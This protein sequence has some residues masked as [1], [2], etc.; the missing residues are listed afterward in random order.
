MSVVAIG[1]MSG[2]SLDGVDAALITTDGQNMLACGAW[3][4][5]PYDDAIRARLRKALEQGVCDAS[6][7]RALTLWHANAVQAL[8]EAANMEAD[9]V[10]VIGFHGQTIWHDPT[11]GTSVQAGDGALLAKETGID[12][13]YQFRQA[14]LAHGGQG[15]PLAPLFHRAVLRSK[16][17]AYPAVFLNIGGVANLTWVG[18]QEAKEDAILAFDTGPGNALMDDWMA[19]HTGAPYD[20]DGKLAAR[21]TVDADLVTQWMADPFFAQTPPK[22]LDRNAFATPGLEGFNLEDGLACLQAFTVEAIVRACDHL[23]V[24]PRVWYATGGGVHN[25]ALMEALAARVPGELKR[26]EALGLDAD[27]I[28]AQAFGY[29]AVRH[30]QRLPLTLPQTTGVPRPLAGGV[31]CPSG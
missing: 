29:L 31:F 10:D 24:L 26:V 1:L 27:A 12:V 2:T 16:Q 11:Q 5:L 9:D 17:T 23:P 19:A 18:Q 4:T 22:S 7:E 25:V 20:T 6:T 30:M 21:G 13:V 3:L 28:E 15:A 8:L 14:D